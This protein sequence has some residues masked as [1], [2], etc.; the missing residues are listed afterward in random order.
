MSFTFRKLC[1]EKK[2]I[3]HFRLVVIS[4]L[5][6]CVFLHGCGS[7][8]KTLGIDRDPP[9]EFE[10]PSIQPLDMPPDF[11]ALP[12][13]KP[14]TPRPQDVSERTAKQEKL[15]GVST[16]QGAVSPG[17]KALLEM[18]GAEEGQDEIREKI[19]TESRIESAKGK[20]LLQK[21][22]IK[23]AKPKDVINPYEETLE[24]QK[25]GVP[26]SRPSVSE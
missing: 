23:K 12:A 25:K 6:G 2:V 13:P 14:G 17:Q 16:H 9:D 15:L 24:L 4:L 22:G 7:V 19:D 20:P 8:K 5:S 11:F 1:E 18:A 26:Q 21:L 10:V 3:Q